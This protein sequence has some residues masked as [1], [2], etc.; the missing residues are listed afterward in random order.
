MFACRPESGLS[1]KTCRSHKA[2]KVV[3]HVLLCEREGMLVF[4]AADIRNGGMA[5]VFSGFKT[6]VAK[7]SSPCWFHRARHGIKV[8]A[9]LVGHREMSPVGR[10]RHLVLPSEC[11][12]VPRYYIL[13]GRAM[14]L[15]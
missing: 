12:A 9:H 5:V 6:L 10:I 13:G 11:R 3:V 14:H 15:V 8:C 2:M 7:R 4:G 1:R